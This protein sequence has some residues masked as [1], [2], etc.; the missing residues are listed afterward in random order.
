MWFISPLRATA[1][2]IIVAAFSTF[3]GCASAAP[4]SAEMVSV[5]VNNDLIPPTAI[6][7]HANQTSGAGVR[8]RVGDV[9]PGATRTLT[10]AP[11]SFG[12]EFV[13]TARTTAGQEIVSN[14]IVI[15]PPESLEWRLSANI[16]SPIQ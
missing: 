16:L 8:R 6:T 10:F 2:V 3:Q 9:E 7:V 11:G 14:P 12:G 13:F 1:F 5:R 4:G 15:T